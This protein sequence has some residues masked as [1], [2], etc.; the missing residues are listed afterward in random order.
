MP[1]RP[2]ARVSNTLLRRVCLAPCGLLALALASSAIYPQTCTPVVPCGDSR[3][4]GCPDLTV[5]PAYLALVSSQIMT[6]PSTDCAVVED[7]VVAG[8]RNMLLFYTFTPNLGPGDLVLGNPEDHPDWFD[9]VTCHG[10]PHLKDYAAFRLWK[11]MGYARWQAL[12]A[13]TPGVC[14]DEIFAAHPDLLTQLVSGTKHAF[15]VEDE[16]PMKKT[17]SLMCPSH[18]NQSPLFDCG[19]QGISVCWA[20]VYFPGLSGQWIDITGVRD[21]EYV[22]ENEVNDKHFMTETDYSNNS[23]AVTIE[24]QGGIPS[25]LP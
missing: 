13:A 4:R 1:R 24:I 21:G 2:H 5:D 8:T 11:P 23:A 16:N 15:C 20:D 6:F 18:G 12:R 17:T 19:F 22:L 10:H 25:V 14:A 3:S 9:L 7:E